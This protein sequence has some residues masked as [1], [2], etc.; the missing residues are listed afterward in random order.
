MKYRMGVAAIAATALIA[1]AC[2]ERDGGSAPLFTEP[3]FP[4]SA[5]AYITTGSASIVDPRTKQL[6]VVK[7]S[8]L[9]TAP[10]V[11]ASVAAGGTGQVMLLANGAPGIAKSDGY[12]VENFVDASKH[13]HAL[14]LLYGHFGGPPAAVQHYVD[15]ALVS[16][17]AYSWQH[18]TTG[19]LRTTSLT[20][21]VQKGQLIG[22]YSAT[23]APATPPGPGKGGGG[24]AIPVR[25]ERPAP[26]GLDRMLGGV[27]YAL[28]FAIAP[29]DAS[30]QLS[31]AF[32]AC[33]QEWL[34]FA[35]AAAIIIGLDFTISEM[36]LITPAVTAQFA[37]ALAQLGA[38]ED[39][40]L[41]CIMEH[42][43]GTFHSFGGGGGPG[44]G[45]GGGGDNSC[46]EGSYAAHCTTPFTL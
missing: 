7:P 2:G 28:A 6:R 26:R 29:Q 36:P 15:K 21:V 11:S 44:A 16:T 20:R 9:A 12:Y 46:L 13:Q 17:T 23:T 33:A 38:A 25:L 18:T 40:L 41:R 42:Q 19:W 8:E 14:V 32:G 27:A 5:P 3:G 39:A 10:G 43:P 35:A 4:G 24:P 1:G 34:R 22:T 45:T 37:A 30:A 31:P